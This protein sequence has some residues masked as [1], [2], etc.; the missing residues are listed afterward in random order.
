MFNDALTLSK[1]SMDPSSV[2]ATRALEVIMIMRQNP[3]FME[4]Y[5]PGAGAGQTNAC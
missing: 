2:L 3:G 5:C 1:L 4:S